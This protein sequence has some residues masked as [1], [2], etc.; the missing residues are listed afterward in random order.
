MGLGVVVGIWCARVRGVSWFQ[1]QE[2]AGLGML[3]DESLSLVANTL[4]SYL[5]WDGLNNMAGFA[6]IPVVGWDNYKLMGPDLWLT[7]EC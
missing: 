1:S 6:P 7:P 2:V 4:K 3:A 5:A